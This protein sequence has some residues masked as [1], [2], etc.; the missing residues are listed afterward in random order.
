[1]DKLV[2]AARLGNVQ[3]PVF[4][5]AWFVSAAF[6]VLVGVAMPLAGSVRRRGALAT[7]GI[8]GIRLIVGTRR[9]GYLGLAAWWAHR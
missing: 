1:M 2:R 9:L 7:C 5:L 6:A 8:V 3:L 4:A